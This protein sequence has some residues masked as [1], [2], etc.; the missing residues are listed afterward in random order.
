[1]LSIIGTVW[2]VS[3]SIAALL[4]LIY[5]VTEKKSS[6]ILLTTFLTVI[7]LF[8]SGGIIPKVFFPEALRVVAAYLPSTFWLEGIAGVLEG[9]GV[10]G[11]MC[12]SLLYGML[13]FAGAVC[14]RHKKV[15]S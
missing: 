4:L 2:L 7:L 9:R 8:L 15:V 14:L 11:K 5:E 13:F 12:G 10:A 6:A 1:M 3:G